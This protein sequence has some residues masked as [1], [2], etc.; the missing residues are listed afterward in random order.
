MAEGSKRLATGEEFSLEA[1][2]EGHQSLVTRTESL[3]AEVH[4]FFGE[5]R[6]ELRQINARLDRNQDVRANVPATTPVARRGFSTDR[7]RFR[8]TN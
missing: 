4:Q 8:E 1:L 2:W 5:M 3:A 7:G 6:R